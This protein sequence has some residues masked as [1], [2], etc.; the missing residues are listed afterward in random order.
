[1]VP[2][3]LSNCISRYGSTRT[4]PRGQPATTWA[5]PCTG[6][7][8]RLAAPASAVGLAGRIITGMSQGGVGEV[9]AKRSDRICGR[10][11]LVIIYD[12][13][14]LGRYLKAFSANRC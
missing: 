3:R 1:V 7:W 9:H 4:A 14:Y 11:Q 10:H 8:A 5:T 13:D 6:Q 12:C 2:E